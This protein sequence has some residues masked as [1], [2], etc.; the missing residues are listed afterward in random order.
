[1]TKRTLLGFGIGVGFLA[2]TACSHPAP[3]PPNPAV[4]ATS[5][6]ASAAAVP[7]AAGADLP[8]A[9][10]Q[11]GTVATKTFH[12]DALGVDKSYLVYL[13]EG[14]ESSQ[15]RYPVIY[16]LHGL[17][18]DETN[19]IDYGHADK[20]ADAL[21]LHA[22]LVFPD[23]DSSFY[24]NGATPVDY[25]ACVQKGKGVFGR[26]ADNK[27]F[28]VKTPKYEDYVVK[29]LV[30]HID[31]TYRTVPERK[32]RAISGN[33]MGGFGAL[34][35]AMRHPDVFGSAVSHSGVDALL[36]QGPYPYDAAHV[37]LFEDARGWGEKAEPIGAWVRG[38]FG[39]DINNWKAHD[40]AVLGAELKDGAIAIYLDGGSADGFGLDAGARYLHDVLTKAGVKHDFTIVDGG[41]HDFSL[42]S[43]RVD[44]GMKFH[45]AFFARSGL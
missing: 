45:A 18:G 40:P 29:D 38:V 7:P 14:Y 22:I 30:G 36:Y 39:R 8:I 44:E 35:L 31:A 37:Q 16:M 20:V 6:A 13:P 4:A 25:D 27:T 9:A 2:A 33:S 5:Q 23:G 17:G 41:K 10:P 11:K 1:M 28:C 32:A 19:W 3:P 15:T 24:V 34:Q 26:V 43:E 21:G 12:S 42:W